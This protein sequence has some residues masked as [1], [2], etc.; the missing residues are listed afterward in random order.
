MWGKTSAKFPFNAEIVRTLRARLRQGRLAKL[1]LD[2][3]Q[4]TVHSEPDSE[5]EKEPEREVEREA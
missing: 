5:P 3:E 4:S 2:K 1:E